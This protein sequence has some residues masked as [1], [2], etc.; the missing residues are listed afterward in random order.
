MVAASTVAAP[1]MALQLAA[2]SSPSL[3]SAAAAYVD[4]KDSAV[5]P[6]IAST[7]AARPGDFTRSLTMGSSR[8]C[9]YLAGCF[10]GRFA[11]LAWIGKNATL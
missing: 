7:A 2:G 8:R 10:T 6:E 9:F 11:N 3:R 4:D 5:T 1:A